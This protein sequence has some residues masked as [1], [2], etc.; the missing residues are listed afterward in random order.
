MRNLLFG[1]LMGAIAL[2]AFPSTSKAGFI[3]NTNSC[4]SG[5]RFTNGGCLVPG[6]AFIC[7]KGN[8]GSAPQGF[9]FGP[10]DKK[11]NHWCVQR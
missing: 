2:V 9:V 3:P 11:G 6:E 1:T 8:G 10:T 7:G 4:P 5:G